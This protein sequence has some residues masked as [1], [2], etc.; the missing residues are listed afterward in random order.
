MSAPSRFGCGGSQILFPMKWGGMS[1]DVALLS[2]LPA[3]DATTDE[4]ETDSDHEDL[5]WTRGEAA[6]VI[7]SG[8]PDG[9]VRRRS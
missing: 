2:D 3:V 6:G 9:D 7:L 5:A 1:R 4:G 8:K